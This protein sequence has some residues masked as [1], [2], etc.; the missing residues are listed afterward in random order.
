M[1]FTSGPLSLLFNVYIA[2]PKYIGAGFYYFYCYY[3]YYYYYNCCRCDQPQTNKH[4]LSNCSSVMSLDLYTLRH[5]AV[6]NV[7]Y[8]WINLSLTSSKSHYKL[9]ADLEGPQFVHVDTVF[10]TLR[11]D[12]VLVDKQR[13]VTLELTVC[14]ESNL[15]KSRQYK[16]D[17]Y[18]D[19]V[20]N[21]NAD[22]AHFAVKSFTV[23]VTTLG[24]ISDISDFVKYIAIS[25]MPCSTK[26]L[27][28]LRALSKSI[29][30]YYAR[31]KPI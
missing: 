22:F 18:K 16:T 8:E 3:D 31:N 12:I 7:L 25:K 29:E 2:Q 10:K 5:N 13:V 30:I 6:L 9:F 11:P 1:F 15:C 23:E 4:V 24:L 17:R 20:T 26:S 27:I 19:I 21:L 14:H 28:T